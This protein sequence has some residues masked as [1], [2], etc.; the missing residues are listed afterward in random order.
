MLWNPARHTHDDRDQ[1][2]LV[3]QIVE[4]NETLALKYAR[5]L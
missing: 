3:R 2:G 5:T 1:H 4:S